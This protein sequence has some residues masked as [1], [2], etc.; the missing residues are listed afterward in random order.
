MSSAW[1]QQAPRYAEVLLPLPLD[2]PYI[3]ALPENLRVQATV[4]MRAQVPLGNTTRVGI[5]TALREQSDVRQ[6]RP[7]ERLLDDAPLL[8]EGL[9]SFYAWLADYY[10]A[11]LGSVLDLALPT[12]LLLPPGTRVFLGMMGKKVL[13]GFPMSAAWG[14]DAKEEK[15]LLKLLGVL[16]KSGPL[17]LGKALPGGLTEARL[18]QWAAAE[19]VMLK[20]E[21]NPF[22]VK[23]ERVYQWNEEA[24]PPT[25]RAKKQRDIW[26][27]LQ[28][29]PQKTS[30]RAEL[31]QHFP[32]CQSSL[33]AMVNKELVL[34]DQRECLRSPLSTQLLH[35]GDEDNATLT[36]TEEQQRAVDAI[37][38]AL[39]QP[40]TPFLLHGV[41]GSG[42]TEVY[43]RA[44]EACLSR[45]KQVLM[46]LPEIALAPQVVTR[47]RARFGPRVAVWHSALS[48]GERRDEWT[49]ILRD[50]ADIVVGARSAIFAPLK[51]LG[52]IVVDEEHEGSY[53]NEEGVYYHARD[54]A[55]MRGRIEQAAVV[56]GSATPSVESINQVRLKRYQRLSLRERPGT[57]VLPQV[58]TVALPYA[59]KEDN[60]LSSELLLACRQRLSRGEQAILFLN[61]RGFSPYIFCH[62]CESPV[63]CPHCAVSLTYHRI[64][65]KLLC[66][67]CGFASPVP[68]HCPSCESTELELKGVGTQ[69][70]EDEISQ[71]FPEARVARLDRDVLGR[72][73]ELTRLLQEVRA[74]DIDLLIGTQMVAKGH[75]FPG[76]TLV[77]VLNADQSLHFPDFRAGERT[78]QL[79]TQVSGRSGRRDIPGQVLIQT[80]SPDHPAIRC[81]VELD[82]K[83]FYKEE[84]KARHA[85]GYPPFTRLALLRIESRDEQQAGEVSHHLADALRSLVHK[86][87]LE[88]K[89]F[90]LGPAS[91]PIAKIKDTFRFHVLV[92]SPT[93]RALRSLLKQAKVR[94][95]LQG[96]KEVRIRLDIDPVHML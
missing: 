86:Q 68:K 62:G 76:V 47:L 51:K 95:L 93:V 30:S 37:L 91:A 39:V 35:E 56:L 31:L 92:K 10:F 32:S 72:K 34:E 88:G 52:L 13:D 53:K 65:G 73:G 16:R 89:V 24:E 7:L 77:A 79:L 54:M 38:P 17:P 11:P 63:Q 78:F 5:I 50:E 67:L 49:R 80:D 9:L 44:M 82:D 48:H 26:A 6:I 66:H 28:E 58:D 19:L 85:L 59:T 8:G 83:G 96:G 41:T 84:L 20:D 33:K 71:S 22:A 14:L 57:T 23:T 42:K 2:T 29:C 21:R 64:Q 70:V 69:K 4:G 55:V 36:L 15:L 61:R 25:A 40:D 3:Y 81:A 94:E 43:L 1:D 18:R 45:G 90:V 46:L 74:G 75:D 60:L 27:Y 12:G 87:N